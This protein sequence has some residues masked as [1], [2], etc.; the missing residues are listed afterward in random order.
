MPP[1]SPYIIFPY[2]NAEIIGYTGPWHVVNSVG[3][4]KLPTWGPAG[5]ERKKARFLL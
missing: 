4:R 1:V 5:T 2:E 3:T